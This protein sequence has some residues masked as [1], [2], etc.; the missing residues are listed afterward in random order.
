[1]DVLYLYYNRSARICKATSSITL[2]FPI[3]FLFFHYVKIR[4][5]EGEPRSSA[6]CLS[7]LFSFFAMLS[8]LAYYCAR[9]KFY[10][11][12]DNQTVIW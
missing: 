6:S 5:M 3:L 7:G 10:Y 2:K 1:M 8:F 9:E 11:P 12:L 4:I